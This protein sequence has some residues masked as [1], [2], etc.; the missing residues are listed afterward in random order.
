MFHYCQ[1]LLKFYP[2]GSEPD[3][4]RFIESISAGKGHLTISYSEEYIVFDLESKKI[5]KRG[6]G[7][8]PQNKI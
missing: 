7:N 3:P 8:R 5:M 6:K 1:K 2:Q 4:K